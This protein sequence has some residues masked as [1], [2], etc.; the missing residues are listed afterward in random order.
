MGKHIVFYREAT[1]TT[2]VYEFYIVAL[3]SHCKRI[4]N[5]V[6]DDPTD[7]RTTAEVVD[8]WREQGYQLDRVA[9]ALL[10][11]SPRG[12]ECS[13]EAQSGECLICAAG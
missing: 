2:N 7:T 4:V 11:N 5:Y 12:C 3:C 6:A 10:W 13:K 1:M 9:K 8:E